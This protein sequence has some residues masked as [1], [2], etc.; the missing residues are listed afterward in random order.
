MKSETASGRQAGGD[1]ME[2]IGHDD[3]PGDA[4]LALGAVGIEEGEEVLAIGVGGEGPLF[5]VAALGEV[6]PVAWRGET[7]P[8]GH[9]SLY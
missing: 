7:K 1:E 3:I 4:D 5:V 9:F 6:Q 2:V 8:A